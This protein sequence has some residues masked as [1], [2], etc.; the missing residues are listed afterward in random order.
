M[1]TLTDLTTIAR[2]YLRD[3][4][5]FFQV[6]T[7]NTTRTYK[8]SH[9]NVISTSLY[10]A[11]QTTAATTIAAGSNGASLPQATIN[12]AS[13]TG[14]ASSGS[15]SVVTAAGTQ[16]VTYTGLTGTTFTGCTGGTGAMATGGAVAQMPIVLASGTGYNLDARNGLLRLVQAP[17]AG[18]QLMVEGYYY[19]WLMDDDLT[20]AA[21]MAESLI[22]SNLDMTLANA[23]AIVTDIAGIAT[24][25]E[26]LWSLASE[27]SRDIDVSNPEGVHVPA[28]DRFRM[29]MP[30]LQHWTGEYEKRARA[31]N[32]GL[33]RIENFTLRRVSRTTNLLVPI[34][35]PKEVGDSAPSTRLFPPVDSGIIPLEDTEDERVD[36]LVDIDPPIGATTTSF[37]Q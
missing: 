20:F 22:F 27:F 24:L 13:T 10:V 28:S 8:L 33:E 2:N 4:P 12:V 14:F 9:P 29:L 6:V 19:E 26:A 21:T 32:I 18:S 5:K 35:R 7:S 34:Y 11:V 17:S 16:T 30:L 25:V 37:Y 36:A 31:L 23:S 1:A 15:I 3:F